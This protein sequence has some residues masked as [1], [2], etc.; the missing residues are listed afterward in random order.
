MTER[1][2]RAVV[3]AAA[4]LAV[5]ACGSET[6]AP[7]EPMPDGLLRPAPGPTA[8]LAP[9]PTF[10]VPAPPPPVAWA[11]ENRLAVT[12]YG[13]SSCPRGPAGVSAGGE[14]EVLVAI[15]PLFPD[16]D[17]C[18]ADVAPR[19]TVVDLPTG[20]SADEPVTVRLR[21]EDDDEETVV[22]PPAGR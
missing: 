15:R 4:V 9:G 22:L 17:P 12:T 19:R 18:T 16:R 11:G 7:Q 20:I 21:H 14:Q 6:A 10:E 13:S 3:L 1:A 2:R 5:G 8:P